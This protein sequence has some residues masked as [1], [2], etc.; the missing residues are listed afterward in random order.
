MNTFKRKSLNTAVLAG[1]ATIVAGGAQAVHQN[2][3]GHGQALVYPYYTVRA[4]DGGTSTAYYDTYISVVNTTN[5]TKA[6][7]VRFMEGKR[8]AEVLDFN[9]YLSPLDVWTGAVVR[10]ANGARLVSSDKS[11]VV[12]Q[13][14][15][16]NT[17]ST[18]DQSTPNVFKNFVYSGDGDASL[19]RA[20]EGHFEILEMGVVTEAALTAAIKHGSNSIPANCTLIATRD[21]AIGATSLG[22]SVSR[23]TGGLF[24]GAS[25]IN[26]MGGTDVSYDAIA[27]DEWFG[28]SG[29]NRWTPADSVNPTLVEGGSSVSNVFLNG[30]NISSQWSGSR[31]AVSATMM[32][33]TVMNE[34]VLDRATNSG[35][36]WVVTF[37][38]KFAYSRPGPGSATPPFNANF[39]RTTN[40]ACD[41][42]SF[43][44]VDR[45]EQAPVGE[46]IVPGA[47]PVPPP[48]PAS[49]TNLC[50]EAN[51]VTFNGSKNLGSTNE[52]AITVPYQNG[53]GGISFGEAF[54][55]LTPTTT[56]V[57]GAGTAPRT[58][59]GLP[60][61][62]FMVQDFTNANLT[63]PGM[64]QSVFSV[65]GGQFHHK[66]ITRIQ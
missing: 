63:V 56:S 53:W 38:T 59:F 58:H 39:N 61:V 41:R 10:T 44:F 55:F 20:R 43:S 14:L 37:P 62:G 13:N 66:F 15:F 46:N 32:H 52:L 57:N 26:V 36:D 12:P 34:Y 19:D 28:G 29:S 23:P 22:N 25:L 50:W 27:L 65:Y 4:V 51:V 30:A 24:G 16:S 8:T 60:V 64:T 6:V 17:G 31:D 5:S 33:E 18:T 21:G 9:L 2:P 11:C 49:T 54:N 3:D 45:E 1:L 48:T 40:T 35:T 7:K 42:V 47:S